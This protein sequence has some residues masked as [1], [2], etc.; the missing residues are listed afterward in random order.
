MSS[1]PNLTDSTDPQ[2]LRARW[3]RYSELVPCTNAFIDTRTPGS[4]RKENFTII[5]PGVAEN[6]DQHVHIRLP[7]GFNIGGARQPP[8][9]TNSQHSHKTAEV[10]VVLQGGFRFKTGVEGDR[11]AVDLGPGDVISIPTDAFRGFDTVGAETSFMFAVLGGD[12]PGRVLWAPYVFEQA[13]AHGL[14]LLESGR[15]IDTANGGKIPPDDPP[16][17]PT[18]AAEAAR[19]ATIDSAGIA[20][21]TVRH[22]SLVSGVPL[23]PFADL[24][25]V[26]E[27]PIIGPANPAEGL[28]AAPLGWLHGFHL[29][30]LHLEPGA[31]IPPHRRSEEEVILMH[32]GRLVVRWA[33]GEFVL[34]PGDTFTVP[35]GL[36]HSFHNTEGTKAECYV[37]RGGDHPAAPAFE[38]LIR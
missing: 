23:G 14:V 2:A 37:V 21:C 19:L 15:L 1:V 35:I 20:A 3:V 22:L 27:T 38:P 11:G 33:Q 34:E 18:T 10:F 16:V 13:K 24:P 32:S 25:G 5:G 4:D 7:H 12:D 36:V 9:C 17:E 26:R 6:P 30:A 28:P 31:Q 8:G 29:R